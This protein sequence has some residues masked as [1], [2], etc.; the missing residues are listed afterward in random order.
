[1]GGESQER[2][3]SI[4]AGAARVDGVAPAIRPG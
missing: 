4:P 2:L 1:M 3:V